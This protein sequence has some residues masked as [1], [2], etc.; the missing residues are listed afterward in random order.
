M[1]TW[2]SARTS[3]RRLSVVP[4][5]QLVS[6]AV[7]AIPLA[8]IAA[9]EE[10]L[11]S[12][13]ESDVEPG[14]YVLFF[15]FAIMA[16]ALTFVYVDSLR[17]AVAAHKA[18]YREAANALLALLGVIFTLV[19][20]TGVLGSQ[21]ATLVTAGEQ[22]PSDRDVVAQYFW[23]L[24]DAVPVLKVPATLGWTMPIT[25]PVWWVGALTLLVKGIGGFVVVGALVEWFSSKRRS[26]NETQSS[27]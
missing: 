2:R 11:V 18:G 22:T 27:N 6:L 24:A 14:A 20:I 7:F 4:W 15:L 26:L 8:F 12:D 25:N 17:E 19:L 23:H 21:G 1:E 9:G 3:L 16:V 13:G 10:K 5:A